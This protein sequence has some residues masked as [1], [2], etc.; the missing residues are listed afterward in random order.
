MQHNGR[1]LS[2][3]RNSSETTSY[4]RKINVLLMIFHL[5]LYINNHKKDHQNLFSIR[6]YLIAALFRLFWRRR[7]RPRPPFRSSTT[8]IRTWASSTFVF[9]PMTTAG[10]AIPV[11]S[12]RPWPGSW[13]GSGWTRTLSSTFLFLTPR[14]S[15]GWWWC[16][17]ITVVAPAGRT[18]RGC[19]IA[20]TSGWCSVNGGRSGGGCGLAC[21][22]SHFFAKM[23]D[24]MG[25]S[26]N[27]FSH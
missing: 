22:F 17:L 23:R 12:G 25:Q 7:W 2:D 15:M 20:T 21:P 4:L 16:V 8:F 6:Q 3:T 11:W 18:P 19:T 1:K 13:P 5:L 26:G 14:T 10:F 9:M 24:L 27:W